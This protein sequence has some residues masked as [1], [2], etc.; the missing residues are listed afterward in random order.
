MREKISICTFILIALC[1]SFVPVPPPALVISPSTIPNGQ[2]GSPYSNQTLRVTGGK[3]PYTFSISAGHLPSGMSFSSE[4][5]ISGT[6]GAAGTYSFTVLAKDNT[7][8]PN[9]L[10]GSQAYTLVIDKA[11]LTISANNA[12]MT[13][14]GAVPVLTG[15]YHGFVNGDGASSLSTQP[16]LTTTA[17][18]SSAAG[19]YSI[20]ASGAVAT[21][22]NISYTSGTLTVNPASLSVSAKAQTKEFAAPDPTLTYTASGFVNGDNTNLFTGSLTRAAGENVGA[23]P[24]SQGSLSAGGNYRIS[25]TG[26]SLTITK[27]SQNI[28]WTQSLLVGCN[29]TTQISLTAT[30]SSGLPIA[31]SISDV[32]VATISGNVLTLVH[33]G[34]AVI[35]A[36]QAGDANHTAAQAVTDTVLY[37]PASLISQHWEDAI[38]FDNSS[39]DYVQWQWYKNGQPVPGATDPFYSET[40]ALNGQYFVIATNKSGKQ[41]QSCTL[42]IT[43]NT[44]I[45]GGIK[46]HPNPTGT[47][48][49]ATV[50]SNYTSAALQGA[51]LQIVDIKGKMLQQLPN[52]QPSMQI[53]MPSAT[54]IYIINLLLPGGQRVSTN[55]LV[56]N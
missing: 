41:I 47:G 9:T 43:A 53:T 54:G 29:S 49:M 1:A 48:S 12:S 18:T 2:Y 15:T 36:N 55:V 31:Y 14:G 6:P 44:P 38:F 34:T 7:K 10:T 37:Q 11:P 16:Q 32:E 25:F 24:I 39:G 5:V 40:P 19:S 8:A 20:T 51:V 22:Y 17:T 35:T 46:V 3:S 28:T 56:T 23:Y 21:N 26:N 42:T 4:G 50:T 27:T 52:V 45:S 13:Y 30:A 33:P